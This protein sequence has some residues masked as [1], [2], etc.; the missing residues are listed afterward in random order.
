MEARRAFVGEKSYRQLWIILAAVL[1]AAMLAAGA[2]LIGSGA[3]SKGAPA[4]P[5]VTHPAPGTVLHQDTDNG[6]SV[7]EPGT[8]KQTVF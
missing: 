8:H 3:I 4:S 2:A 6:P 1:C 7:S 5:V